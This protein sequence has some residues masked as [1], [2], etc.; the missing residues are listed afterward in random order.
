MKLQ[1][2]YTIRAGNKIFQGHN[3]ITLLGESFFLNRAINTEF[4]PIQ[5]ILLGNSSVRAKKSDISLGNE[6]VRKRCVSEADIDKKQLIL[7]CSCSAEEITDTSE[8]GVSNGD[9]L[10]SHDVYDLPDDFITP[11]IDSVEI[12]YVFQLSTATV[13][14][15][16]QYYTSVDTND[17]TFNIYYTVE[18]NMV[19]GVTEEDTKSGYRAVTSLE[20]LKTV[21]GAYYYDVQTH[22]LFIRTT[23]ADNPNAYEIS[24]QN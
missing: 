1:G 6:T 4:E 3:L 15:D 2:S 24:I 22:T 14:G 7:T 17:D 16:W 12:T 5:Y 23:R 20:L 13:R 9:I 8:I 10:I 11:V 18:E 21:K 19:K